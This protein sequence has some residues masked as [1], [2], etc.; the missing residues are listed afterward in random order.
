MKKGCGCRE[1]K[2]HRDCA[3][4]GFGGDGIKVCG[5][6]RAEGIDGPVIRGTSG[7]RCAKHARRAR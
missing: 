5:R 6:C 4:C 3:Y 2:T 1:A 7:R